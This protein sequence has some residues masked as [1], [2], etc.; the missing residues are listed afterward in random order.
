MQKLGTLLKFRFRLWPDHLR[1]GSSRLRPLFVR[2]AARVCER[3]PPAS[4]TDPF[5]ETKMLLA[6][7]MDTES[8]ASD[9]DY[10]DSEVDE[11]DEAV[12]DGSNGI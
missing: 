4:V 11:V 7:A 8:V 6:E 9:I 12:S 10:P 5:D 3:A 2:S 1:L